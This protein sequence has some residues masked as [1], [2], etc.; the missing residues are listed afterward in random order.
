MEPIAIV[1]MSCRLPGDIHSPSQLWE[2]LKQ[3]KD[4][5][6]KIPANRFNVDSWYHPDSHRPGSVNA[7][8]GYF[9]SHDDSF[10][11]FD[12]RFF[13]V[14]SIEAKSMDPQQ[15]KLCETVYECLEAAGARLADMSGSSTG[16]FVGN[17]TYD[18][19]YDQWKD[20]EYVMP[21]QTTGS[22]ATILSNRINYLFNLKGPSLTVDTACSSVMYALHYAIQ[23]IHNGDCSAAI[24]GG[25]NLVF[26]LEQHIGSV[27]L[28]ALSPT[29][30]CH[31]FDESADGYGRADAVGALYVKRLSDAIQNG[32][33]IR[34]I[35]RG[36]AVNTNGRSAGISHPSVHQQ[37]AVI[38]AAYTH[39][40]LP[41]NE[42]SYFEC[43]GTGTQVGDPIEVD[44]IGRVFGDHHSSDNP[45]LIGS[46]KTN[47]GHGEAASAIA[48]IIKAS[49]V[50]ETGQVPAT[51]GIRTLNPHLKLLGGA[52]KI[53]QSTTVL[54]DTQARYRRASVNS[55]GY[56]GA[57][58]HAIL[59]ATQSYFGD[60]LRAQALHA[61]KWLS[62]PRTVFVDTLCSSPTGRLYLLP[63][64]AHNEITLQAIVNSINLSRGSLD[65][66]NLAYTLSVRRELFASRAFQVVRATKNSSQTLPVDP[67][68]TATHKTRCPTIAFVFTGQGAQW[69][70]MGLTLA[71]Q[72][73]IVL[74]T[75]TRL[76]AALASTTIPPDWNILDVLRETGESSR[77]HD[78]EKSQ[79]ICTAL[80]IALVDL[81]HSWRVRAEAV[82]GHSSGE[83][84]AAYA[85]GLCSAEDA[86][87][88]AYFRGLAASTEQHPGAMMAV[89][90]SPDEME[91]YICDREDVV[92]A[93][94]NS[95]R[96][97]TLSGST[98]AIESLFVLLAERKIFARVLRTSGNAYHSWL[99]T[100]AGI[101]YQTLL[102]EH[103]SDAQ[104]T[105]DQCSAMRA[106]M[107]SSVTTRTIGGPLPTSY[108]R[109]NLTSMVAFNDAI[110]KML[111]MFPQV[112]HVLEI[113]PHSALAG[114][115][116]DIIAKH[117][118]AA[119]KVSY[120]QTLSR[121]SDSAAD[122]LGLA[123]KLFLK[124][125]PL[126]L[127]TVNGFEKISAEKLSDPARQCHVLTSLPPYPWTYTD[128]DQIIP[129]ESRL[130]RDIKFRPFMRHDLLGSRVPGSS[131]DCPVW[132]NVIKLENVPW[133]KDHQI[134][135][136]F[137]F[138]AAGYVAIALE[139]GSQAFAPLKIPLEALSIAD[140]TIGS[141]LLLRKEVA[142]EV[143]VDA[144][145][146]RKTDVELRFSI[147]STASDQWTEHA[148]G[149][150]HAGSTMNGP[151][152]QHAPAKGSGGRW[153]VNADS[154]SKMWF[155]AMSNVGME[156]GP[157]FTL[158]SDISTRAT[159]LEASATV[160]L[161]AT[162]LAMPNQ[163]TYTLHPTVVDAA[164]QLIVI[165]VHEGKP[166]TFTKP[167]IPTVITN[168]VASRPLPS[169]TP[170]LAYIKVTG[171]RQ[172]LRQIVG[173][174]TIT[175]AAQQ[176]LLQMDVELTSLESQ[177][178]TNKKSAA[179]QP[180]N[181]VIW[182]PDF[183]LITAAQ[184][185][186]LL[187]YRQDDIQVK[188][189]FESLN[190]CCILILL[191]DYTRVPAGRARD[192]LPFHMQKWVTWVETQGKLLSQAHHFSEM[193]TEARE[194]RIAA[195]VAEF[196]EDIPEL[197]LVAR[198][199]YHM[200]DIVFG[201]AAPLELMV[202]DGLLSKVYE[203]GFSG[204][205]AYDRLASVLHLIGHKNP[206][207]RILEIGAGS[208]GAT[209]PALN[210]LRGN[211]SFPQYREY[212][213]TDVSTAFLSRAK[214]KFSGYLNVSYAILDIEGVEAQG[215]D[216]GSFDVIIASNVIHATKSIVQTLKNCRKLLAPGGRLILVET[217]EIRLVTGLLVGQ[218]PG[219]WLGVDDCRPD[220]PF[221]SADEWHTRLVNA[222]LSG[223]DHVLHDYSK[224]YDSTAVIVSRNTEDYVIVPKL[225]DPSIAELS[226]ASSTGQVYLVYLDSPHPVL[227]QLEAHYESCGVACHR[228]SLKDLGQVTQKGIRAVIL[229]E[230]EMPVLFE[231]SDEILQGLQHLS[232]VAASAIYVTN[233]GTL[234]GKF[235][236]K[237]LVVGLVRSISIEE[238]SFRVATVDLDPE[239]LPSSLQRA[240]QIV[241]N[242]EI[243]FSKNP[244]TEDDYNFVEQDGVLHISRNIVDTDENSSY[245]ML[246]T[247]TTQ[248]RS[249]P[250]DASAYFTRVEDFDAL[251]W[252]SKEPPMQTPSTNVRVELSRCS[253]DV[254]VAGMLRGLK[255]YPF[256]GIECVGIVQAVASAVVTCKPGDRILYLGSNWLET[257]SNVH[258]GDCVLLSDTS[259]S[260]NGSLHTDSLMQSTS[261][262]IGV[263]GTNACSMQPFRD[264]EEFEGQYKCFGLAWQLYK[265]IRSDLLG[266]SVLIDLPTQVL[267][268]ALS[269]L[270]T[271][272]GSSVTAV[273]KSQQEHHL[274][275]SISTLS[276]TV[277]DEFVWSG[278]CQFDVIITDRI[279]A[280]PD[281]F[282]K[283]LR[284]Q[285]EVLI[286]GHHKRGRQD[287]V[288]QLAPSLLSR[289]FAVHIF[290][291]L[292]ALSA[293]R[294][295]L[296]GSIRAVIDLA[297]KGSLRPAPRHIFPL[298]EIKDAVRATQDLDKYAAVTLSREPGDLV[299]VR[300]RPE[301]VRFRPD[302]SYILIGCLGGL[303][304]VI[305]M[306]M[307][308]RGARH[309]TFLSRSAADKPEAASLV[310]ELAELAEREMP[311]LQFDIVR[312]DV[313]NAQHV[314][315]TVDI[316]AAQG[317]IRG[318]IHAAMVLKE[319][320]F[321]AMTLDI[322][323]QVVQPKVR[324]AQ[325]LH[326]QTLGCDLDFFVMTSTI[327]SVVGA[328]TQS[329]Y[330]A[331]NAYLDHL[332]R[333]RH[334]RG[335]QA[336]SI[337]IGMVVNV[338][339]VEEHEAS[340]IALRRNGMYGINMEEFLDNLELSCRRKDMTKVLDCFDPCAASNL[341]TGMDPTRITRNSSKSIWH[342]DARL[343]HFTQALEQGSGAS[344]REQ[345]VQ[346]GSLAM[347][348]REAAKDGEAAARLKLTQLLTERIAS[349]VMVP[350]EQ[351][352][353]GDALPA[354]GMDSMIGAELRAWLQRELGADV[355]FLVIL[356][357]NLTFKALA[358]IVFKSIDLAQQ[359][360]T[361]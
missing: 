92:V 339:Y 190:E 307:I 227:A 206:G 144:W 148:T 260:M 334:H 212:V 26:G 337:S 87:R 254:Y 222:C 96:S 161:Q 253:L 189:R 269:Q 98:A 278:K 19:A 347:E 318:V 45:L 124:T 73:P 290:D 74:S 341:I 197:A 348:L 115:L 327:L 82:V 105:G 8:G 279:T 237:S 106:T 273:Y 48:S 166:Y 58:A 99:M 33:P 91:T 18:A 44:A 306:W 100:A 55:F 336:T 243:G 288:S 12:P 101:K 322:W 2:Y 23:S 168:L 31:T 216:E 88:I 213:F 121:A 84:A 151:S 209:M 317:P 223:A 325:H 207:S 169:A 349:L 284:G 170:D 345:V 201:R 30:T 28:G 355:P 236:E 251:Y 10:R 298:S 40:D 264:T 7:K 118:S 193:S 338:G 333:H 320:L 36:T 68:T 296:V 346:K 135:G 183:D 230:L 59:D 86:I 67:A 113:G 302:S 208:G 294:K 350:V 324:G 165:A 69:A 211:T 25:T 178:S 150:V 304:R 57:N 240:A 184:L 330:A 323:N 182:R 154:Y 46:V 204:A 265:T 51:V 97:V 194:R 37:E 39:A 305:T 239:A 321:N 215:F 250:S 122:M 159:T 125:L 299:P 328:A 50:L 252:D 259:K 248:L 85:A 119:E 153:G 282:S 120:L 152:G 83:I 244:D 181:R 116:R 361:Q 173:T 63:F 185:S 108:W 332:A 66:P 188:I 192:D 354:Y 41:L 316:A 145:I 112:D 109:Q 225:E 224:P 214:D 285:G 310:Q 186:D 235:P 61:V 245:H 292:E 238:P 126:D 157:G 353:V 180:Y 80:Q 4:A 29:S 202:K 220:G 76:D 291:V 138:P 146:D 54:S 162:S 155:E 217:T 43:H 312:G 137:V 128:Q 326:Q 219:Y 241:A 130:C 111:D 266:K 123:G 199:H 359:N 89:G 174:A 308:S 11:S 329:N 176:I 24:V 65:V 352:D 218:L 301:P 140:L 231:L 22:G 247:E 313:S 344:V 34:A 70:H 14:S 280:S 319:S 94:H 47:L 262:G 158:L 56:G 287:A 60:T 79:T 203:E 3:G 277:D 149:I 342:R 187:P 104:S 20:I 258:E 358:G 6:S 16:C 167:Y 127:A 255:D 335:L 90:L 229:V 242:V 210:A 35:I 132:R 256:H 360:I 32:D 196:G 62:P 221:I 263:H 141:A 272:H 17:F 147:K 171:K 343:R 179:V 52:I 78:T 200:S 195:L 103:F 175:D 249:C 293:K 95:P 357:Q 21:Y 75:I 286:V 271:M 81:L 9:L 172:G 228:A 134:A 38:R 274:L 71:D 232:Q 129:L 117:P 267:G 289:G 53:C 1:G 340:A 226:A 233:A 142:V 356:D 110:G 270:M 42:T 77:I 276:T 311:D 281:A 102:D 133:L 160:P 143:I 15:R 27:A 191:N 315:K 136:N 275:G 198:L 72:F 300:Q 295:Q 13:G 139:A 156:Y 64:A 49:M 351:I 246:H 114:P 268:Y 297:K 314:K 309:L 261:N 5:Q 93:C 283:C 131:P 303:G 234:C 257:T 205:G 107:V 177:L 331:A 164:F 163:S